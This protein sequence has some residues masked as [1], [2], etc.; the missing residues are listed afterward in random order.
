M[1]KARRREESR[2]VHHGL[3]RGEGLFIGV[4]EEI[5][6]LTLLQCTLNHSSNSLGEVEA[7]GGGGIRPGRTGRIASQS[8]LSQLGEGGGGLSWG[9][10][11]VI[12]T[13]TWSDPVERR[14][15]SQ[16]AKAGMRCRLAKARSR[17]EG[18]DEEVKGKYV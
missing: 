16:E 4:L 7:G 10:L 1:W 12:T 17:T 11:N 9:E 18:L 2:G 3:D 6:A 13:R 15:V 5:R 8:V 14:G